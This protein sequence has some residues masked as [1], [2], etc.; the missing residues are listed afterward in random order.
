MKCLGRVNIGIRPGWDG[1]IGDPDF[2]SIQEISSVLA[3]QS[4]RPSGTDSFFL[5]FQAR[6]AR[7]A[8]ADYGAPEARDLHDHM[9][10]SRRRPCGVG[11]RS[12]SPSGTGNIRS[13]VF[14]SD[15]VPLRIA[16]GASIPPF[17]P[18]L[19]FGG[20]SVESQ[21]KSFVTFVIQED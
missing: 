6:R 21:E 8:F 20:C 3:E 9:L 4:H 15:T 19:Q 17:Q 14:P 11:L 12:C 13:A 1:V 7:S 5:P 16:F 10:R 2:I 18:D